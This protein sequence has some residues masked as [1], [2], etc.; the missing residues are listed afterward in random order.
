MGRVYWIKWIYCHA[1][2]AKHHTYTDT[3]PTQWHFV[4]AVAF[5][6]CVCVCLLLF[7]VFNFKFCRPFSIGS[8][9]RRSPRIGV[10]VYYISY[11]VYAML[12]FIEWPNGVKT[13]SKGYKRPVSPIPLYDFIFNRFVLVEFKVWIVFVLGMCSLSHLS[14]V[15]RANGSIC[16]MWFKSNST[17]ICCLCVRVCWK[18]IDQSYGN[19]I[20]SDSQ[21]YG[22]RYKSND[23]HEPNF[24]LSIF[25][26]KRTGN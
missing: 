16:M 15:A 12:D 2:N 6:E 14:R 13:T 26:L 18:L 9:P 21:K 19:A 3:E 4:S 5:I 17:K 20:T 24:I 10:W 22:N 23:A 11:E 7:I 8:F 1:H 25:I